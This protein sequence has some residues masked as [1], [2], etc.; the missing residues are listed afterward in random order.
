MAVEKVGHEVR[1]V[2]DVVGEN[3]MAAAAVAEY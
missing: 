3:R 1:T 2:V